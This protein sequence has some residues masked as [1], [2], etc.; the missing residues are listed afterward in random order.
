MA[1]HSCDSCTVSKP[2]YIEKGLTVEELYWLLSDGFPKGEVHAEEAFD[3][4]DELPVS[5]IRCDSDLWFLVIKGR[6]E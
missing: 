1:S 3:K 2:L 6:F 5:S 4:L